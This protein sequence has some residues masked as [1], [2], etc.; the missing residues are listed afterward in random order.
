MRIADS[1]RLPMNSTG[2]SWS[3]M[4]ILAIFWQQNE[5]KKSLLFF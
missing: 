5:N 2:S 1:T 3:S 4:Q